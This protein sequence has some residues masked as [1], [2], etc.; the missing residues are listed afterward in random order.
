MAA[1]PAC[2]TLPCWFRSSR[3]RTG[4]GFG[5]NFTKRINVCDGSRQGAEIIIDAIG[6]VPQ[7][8]AHLAEGALEQPQQRPLDAPRVPER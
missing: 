4:D 5:P 7:P 3:P 1:H 2:P 8:G 6:R